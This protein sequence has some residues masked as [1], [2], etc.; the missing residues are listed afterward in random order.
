MRRAGRL[1]NLPKRL[2][3]GSQLRIVEASQFSRRFLS[4]TLS[5]ERAPRRKKPRKSSLGPSLKPVVALE[6]P[7]K[8]IVAP[9]RESLV[10]EEDPDEDVFVTSSSHNEQDQY[11]QDETGENEN[12]GIP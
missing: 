4:S 10:E 2:L 9:S 5:E 11:Q 12:V 6:R 3:S 8:P 1:L 7:T